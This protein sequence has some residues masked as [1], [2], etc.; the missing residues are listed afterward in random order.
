MPFRMASRQ[1]ERGLGLNCGDRRLLVFANHPVAAEFLGYVERL[2]RAF[3]KVRDF[4]ARMIG[5][6]PQRQRY[7]A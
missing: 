7:D 6:Y 5:R 2:I 1:A 3:D 4:F